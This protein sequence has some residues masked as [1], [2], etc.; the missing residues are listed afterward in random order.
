MSGMLAVSQDGSTHSA[1]DDTT[2][3]D[4]FEFLMFPR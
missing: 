2:N 4:E 1:R 3:R